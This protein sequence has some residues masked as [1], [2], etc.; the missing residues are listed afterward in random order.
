MAEF[1]LCFSG[2]RVFVGGGLIDADLYVKGESIALLTSRGA[3]REAGRVLD[4]SGKFILPGIID[5]HAHTRDPGYTHK[6][7]FFTVSQAAAAGGIT[8]WVDMPNVE[9]PTTTAELL[10]EKRARAKKASLVDFGHFA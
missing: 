1:D 7:D 3:S 10:E 2:G 9:P 8:T 6:E 5:L 4:V